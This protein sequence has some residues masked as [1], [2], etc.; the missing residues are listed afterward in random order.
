MHSTYAVCKLFDRQPIIEFR[1][2]RNTCKGCNNEVFLK[3]KEVRTRPLVT[4]PIGKL[5]AHETILYCPEC[6][7]KYPSTQLRRL[8]PERCLFGYDVMEHVG[9][10]MF[11]ESRCDSDI[12]RELKSRNIEISEREVAFLGKKFIAYL[13]LAHREASAPIRQS[14]EKRG[15]YILHLDGT[16]D[17]DSPHLIS[18]LDGL[19]Q[20]VLNNIKIPSEKA[21]SI[22][23][24]LTEIKTSFG[25]PLAMV[26][27]MGK[28]IQNAV[29]EVFPGI[30]DYICHFHFLRDIGKDLLEHD[31]GI[32]RTALKNNKVRSTLRQR[33]RLLRSKIDIEPEAIAALKASLASGKVKRATV[34]KMPTLVAFAMIHWILDA[35]SESG[36]YGFPFDRP[37]LVFCQRLKAAQEILREIKD[38]YLTES[39]FAANVKANAP[40]ARLY[41]LITELLHNRQ[42]S[43]AIKNI[44]I[45]I[46]IFE[47]LRN[48]MRIALPEEQAGLND[49]GKNVEMGMIENK[50]NEFKDWIASNDFSHNRDLFKGLLSQLNKYWPKLMAAPIT[51]Q[52]AN[53]P[54]IIQPQRTNNDMERLFRDLKRCHRKKTGTSQMSRALR[55]M[56]AD[57]P[58]VR[59]LKNEEYL[60]ILLDGH[61]TLSERF[62]D[63]DAKKVHE[64]LKQSSATPDRIPGQLIRLLRRKSLTDEI[65]KIFSRKIA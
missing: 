58:L 40:L 25:M 61:S 41:E 44:E 39:E 4:M 49:D 45:K 60:A 55:A 51:I 29:D 54:I 53:G 26:H 63:I 17:G 50:L 5:T 18:G 37:H 48:A 47:S 7:E 6:G 42:L 16:C 52:T 31:Y 2:S 56:L 20:I 64:K 62:A 43:I 33:A 65:V 35:N 15:G 28:G 59:N 23:P 21:E 19:S 22:V 12:V 24:F 11:I 34:R 14:M 57:T 10:A 38:Q 27:D 36:G 3:V 30:P 32:I 8:A 1:E 9:R 46:P 13:A